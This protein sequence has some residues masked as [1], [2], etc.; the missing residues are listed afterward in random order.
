[1]DGKPATLLRCN[2]LM[3]GVRVPVGDHEI[4]FRF[5]PPVNSVYVSLGALLVGLGLLGFVCF[6]GAPEVPEPSASRP[7]APN[8]EPELTGVPPGRLAKARSDSPGKSKAR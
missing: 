2:Y 1:V 8:A 5:A 6:A 7:A 3:Q 4:A